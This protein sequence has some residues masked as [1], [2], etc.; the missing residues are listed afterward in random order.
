MIEKGLT[1]K[2]RGRSVET[3]RQKDGKLDGH[4]D[5]GEQAVGKI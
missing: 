1:E 5:T 2:L 4:S 3:R